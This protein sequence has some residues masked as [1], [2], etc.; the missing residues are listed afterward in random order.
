[1]NEEAKKVK[2][3]SFSE[4]CLMQRLVIETQLFL[5]STLI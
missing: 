5:N 3:I 4:I 2:K 1:M